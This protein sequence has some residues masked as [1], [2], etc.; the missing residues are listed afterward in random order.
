MRGAGPFT[1]RRLVL[2]LGGSR[3]WRLN[4]SMRRLL[5]YDKVSA[6]IKE[7]QP[8]G[9]P[10]NPVARYSE[11]KTKALCERH[12]LRITLLECVRLPRIMDLD[13]PRSAPDL[14]G[15]HALR[16]DGLEF[17]NT[18]EPLSLLKKRGR[19]I[20]RNSKVPKQLPRGALKSEPLG[21]RLLHNP[22]LF[23]TGVSPPAQCAR[24]VGYNGRN[25]P[26]RL[27]LP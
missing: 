1:I 8:V 22:K 5:S 24:L 3:L 13:E 26:A 6:R 27:L 23:C 4:L 16:N 15:D 19:R 10:R 18:L 25:L 11:N 14:S 21:T 9:R 20:W 2:S 17:A 12:R 7:L